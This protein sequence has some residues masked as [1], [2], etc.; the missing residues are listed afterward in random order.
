MTGILK[1]SDMISC[2]SHVFI[3]MNMAEILMTKLSQQMKFGTSVLVLPRISYIDLH[4]SS[5]HNTFS[6]TLS[7]CKII[8][9]SKRMLITQRAK[10][11]A[12]VAFYPPSFHHI[13]HS[14]GLLRIMG[15]RHS[16]I[17]GLRMRCCT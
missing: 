6:S 17:Q 5:I 14:E 9:P 8:H 11:K 3:G 1:E 15:L 2:I 4:H 12:Q 10:V 13:S 7:P 16:L